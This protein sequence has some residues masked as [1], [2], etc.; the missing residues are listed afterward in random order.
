MQKFKKKQ[1][2]TETITDSIKLMQELSSL[3]YDSEVWVTSSN[4]PIPGRV[5]TSADTPRSYLVETPSGQI[6]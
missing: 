4:H 5:V 2:Q 6:R 1:E 3:P